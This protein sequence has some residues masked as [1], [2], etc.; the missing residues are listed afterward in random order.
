MRGSLLATTAEAGHEVVVACG[1]ADHVIRWVPGSD[2]LDLAGHPG[3]RD[4]DD[5]L[6]ALSGAPARCRAI[7]E[8]WDGLTAAGADQVLAATPEQLASMAGRARFTAEQRAKVARRD[9]LSDGERA[10][11]LRAFE[12]L[13]FVAEVAGLGPDLARARAK[14]VLGPAWR[15]TLRGVQRRLRG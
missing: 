7:E 14:S 13:L 12:E 4:A 10:R 9:D 8:A 1:G 15:R 2:G 6:V 11:L 3:P 5:V